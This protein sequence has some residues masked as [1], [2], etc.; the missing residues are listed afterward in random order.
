MSSTIATTVAWPANTPTPPPGWD[1]LTDTDG[2]QPSGWFTLSHSGFRGVVKGYP[3]WDDAPW[4]IPADARYHDEDDDYA[5]L[6]CRFDLTYTTYLFPDLDT[7]AGPSTHSFGNLDFCGG[8]LHPVTGV[9]SGL[10]QDDALLDRVLS[11]AKPAAE[12]VGSD[13]D[14][15]SWV[16]AAQAAGL[17]AL[18][19]RDWNTKVWIAPARLGDRVRH[20]A[21][22]ATWHAVAAGDPDRAR[23]DRLLDVVDRGLEQAFALDL[24]QPPVKRGSIV[25]PPW[26]DEDSDEGLVV[27][28][29]VLGYPPASTYARLTGN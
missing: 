16:A 4:D 21:L 6:R 27:L 14:A 17:E 25:T 10:R 26:W 24:R 2:S 8:W 12:L 15:E 9:H 5:V 22:R 23:A 7:A 3:S 29:A 11:G 19:Y 18:V 20:R 1:R 13:A 28:G